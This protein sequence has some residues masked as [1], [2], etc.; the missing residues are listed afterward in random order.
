MGKELTKVKHTVF[1]C[2][3]ISCK[4][5]GADDNAREIRCSVKMMG[6]HENIHTVKTQCLGQC[7]N[8][9][10][11]FLQP[12]NHWYKRITPDV[13]NRFVEERLIFQQELDD[14]LLFR[15][16]WE[17]MKPFKTLMSKTQSQFQEE[18]DPCVG[19]VSSV[20]L[21]PWEFNIYPLLKEIFLV[22]RDT[23]TITWKDKIL[24]SPS[25]SLVYCGG[26]AHIKGVE[27]NSEELIVVMSALKD[28]DRFQYK[29]NAIRIFR[30]LEEDRFGIYLKNVTDGKFLQAEWTADNGLWEHLINHYIKTS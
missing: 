11:L 2:T 29:V 21:F 3:G 24:T 16:G 20:A 25:F 27:N 7:E 6:L 5:E 18:D 1:I 14:H 19:K 10:V 22:Y 15:H 12:D 30:S 8:A 26:D 28:S 4:H 13:V 17:V 9:P 23:L